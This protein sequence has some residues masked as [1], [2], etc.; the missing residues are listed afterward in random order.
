MKLSIIVPLFNQ[1]KLI[2][3]AL[4][5]IPADDRIET[6]VIDDGSEDDSFNVVFDYMKNCNNKN[7]SLIRQKENLGVGLTINR[8]LDN[9][10][11]EYVC[12]MCSDDYYVLDITEMFKYLDGTDM[13]YY[14][15][16][17]NEGTIWT[18]D[19]ETKQKFVGATK[20][21]RNN[22]IGDTRRTSKRFGG[23]Y[24]FYM[25]LLGKSPTE[26]FTNVV[27]YHYNFP[28]E[29]SLIDQMKNGAKD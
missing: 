10:K 17:D 21:M 25:E 7:I 12:I 29:G 9:A 24:D 26:V 15:L 11:G 4:E 3:K 13:V 1:E 22:F 14:N 27:L 28:R 2:L 8:G 5:S 6:I 19:S 16:I 18:L 23:D 20:F